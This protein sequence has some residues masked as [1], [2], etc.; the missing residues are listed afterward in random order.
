MA[1]NLTGTLAEVFGRIGVDIG[2]LLSKTQTNTDN[3][4]TFENKTINLENRI[5]DLINFPPS[6]IPTTDLDGAVLVSN[7]VDNEIVYRWQSLSMVPMDAVTFVKEYYPNVTIES[8]CNSTYNIKTGELTYTNGTL[9]L[10]AA[11]ESGNNT[12]I[13]GAYTT[14]KLSNDINDRLFNLTAR[15]PINESTM[16]PDDSFKV[17]IIFSANASP[18]EVYNNENL[19]SIKF[20]L[21]STPDGDIFAYKVINESYIGGAVTGTTNLNDDITISDKNLWIKSNSDTGIPEPGAPSGVTALETS[22]DIQYVHFIVTKETGIF[23]N[24]YINII[25]LTV[26]PEVS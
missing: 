22:D 15:R 18:I 6:S 25:K 2:N 7:V 20:N 3:I 11:D 21:S 13:A 16:Q 10:G 4:A 14:L 8:I 26:P 24:G 1:L 5:N 12:E 19:Q 9:P 17:N 23:L